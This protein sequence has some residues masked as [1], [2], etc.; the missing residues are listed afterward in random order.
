MPHEAK[1]IC[2]RVRELDTGEFGVLF[3][4]LLVYT[5]KWKKIKHW[6]ISFMASVCV[7]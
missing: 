6:K 1:S 7:L 5:R 3:R 2:P 4:K